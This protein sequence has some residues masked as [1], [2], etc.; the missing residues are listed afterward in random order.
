MVHAFST[1]NS[2]DHFYH[3]VYPS[4]LL[5]IPKVKIKGRSEPSSI[6]LINS[7]ARRLNTT[8]VDVRS[9]TYHVHESLSDRKAVIPLE[10][11]KL[12]I[13]STLPTPR[14]FDVLSKFSTKEEAKLP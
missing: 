3:E 14:L 13:A 9:T 12:E 11:E 2:D 7:M 10:G 1:L 6:S 4:W 5:W 8:S